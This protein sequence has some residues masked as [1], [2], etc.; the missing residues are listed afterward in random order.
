M[1]QNHYVRWK[2]REVQYRGKNDIHAPVTRGLVC[3]GCGSDR[4]F[5]FA[6]IKGCLVQ[7]VK[8]GPQCTGAVGPS[9][10]CACAGS[11]H[12]ANHVRL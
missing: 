3:S 12:G 6:I 1:G 2:D 4:Y 8:C 9:C 11:N 7:A 10:D 5:D